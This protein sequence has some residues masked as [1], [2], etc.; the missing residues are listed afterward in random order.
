[1]CVGA[2]CIVVNGYT[3]INPMAEI[4]RRTDLYSR[5]KLNSDFLLYNESKY[6]ATIAPQSA[7]RVYPIGHLDGVP[8]PPIIPQDHS[9]VC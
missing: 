1:M 5:A 2:H 7:M 8:R 3:V 9:S 4:C 6:R